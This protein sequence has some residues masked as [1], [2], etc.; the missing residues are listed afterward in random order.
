MNLTEQIILCI[1][2]AAL[3]VFLILGIVLLVKIIKLMNE[4]S[5]LTGTLDSLA[6]NADGIAHN[7]KNITYAGSV[8]NAAKLATNLAR[9][10][11]DA[12]KTHDEKR[13]TNASDYHD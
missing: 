3:A 7:I 1:L 10:L 12:K 13:N 11:R 9:I 6:K 5:G 8:A 4:L 2:A